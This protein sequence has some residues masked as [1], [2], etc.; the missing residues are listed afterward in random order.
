MHLAVYIYDNY[1]IFRVEK[2]KYMDSKM[3]P[4]WLDFENFDELGEP[5]QIIF[6]SGDGEH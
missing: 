6:K 1:L 3:K 2:C 4:L 5:V